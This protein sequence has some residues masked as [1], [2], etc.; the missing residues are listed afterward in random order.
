MKLTKPREIVSGGGERFLNLARKKMAELR[1]LCNRI[2]LKTANRSY[3]LDRDTKLFLKVSDAGSDLIYIE[4]GERVSG[5]PFYYAYTLVSGNHTI[6]FYDFADVVVSTISIPQL[7]GGTLQ[8]ILV[9]SDASTVVVT[10]TT[11]STQRFSVWHGGMVSGT[12]DI[13]LT[14]GGAYTRFGVLR[15]SGDGTCIPYF[16]QGA[17]AP[18]SQS[19]GRVILTHTKNTDGTF[20]TTFDDRIIAAGGVA[21]FVNNDPYGIVTTAAYSTDMKYLYLYGSNSVSDAVAFE[22][23]TVNRTFDT[24]FDIVQVS[25][26]TGASSVVLH[27]GS[28]ESELIFFSG[29][30]STSTTGVYDA[31]AVIISPGP[32]GHW[33]ASLDKEFSAAFHKRRENFVYHN[34]SLVYSNSESGVFNPATSVFVSKKPTVSPYALISKSGESFA[35]WDAVLET[36]AAGSAIV[37]EFHFDALG[38]NPTFTQAMNVHTLFDNGYRE[39]DAIA[40]ISSVASVIPFIFQ[41][42]QYSGGASSPSVYPDND[43]VVKLAGVVIYEGSLTE[44]W[45]EHEVP[46]VIPDNDNFFVEQTFTLESK[47]GIPFLADDFT[48]NDLSFYNPSFS[49]PSLSTSYMGGCDWV[50][51]MAVLSD[52]YLTT[53]S[54]NAADSGQVGYG[55]KFE[56]PDKFIDTGTWWVKFKVRKHPSWPPVNISMSNIVADYSN[57]K[58]FLWVPDSGADSGASRQAVVFE[59]SLVN[60]AYEPKVVRITEGFSPTSTVRNLSQNYFQCMVFR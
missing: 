2:G 20:T 35:I 18:M 15:I 51:A 40:P 60:G 36:N 50:G 14:L 7:S 3:V 10:D 43:F 37:N 9:S 28:L 16:K 45:V 49:S 41:R 55:T 44:S 29:M 5:V 34:G 11:A 30:G 42:A 46:I 17:I 33:W 53:I 39:V 6:K 22:T 1:A 23:L 31:S 59:Y 21:P 56:Q 4:G 24:V 54:A 13:D 8:S 38:F 26:D 27:K 48:S 32:N 57:R 52:T 47:Q 58:R 19:E 12:Y 25:L